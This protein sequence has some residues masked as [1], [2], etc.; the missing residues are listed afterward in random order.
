MIARL[1]EQYDLGKSAIQAR[2]HG[3]S[4]AEFGAKHG[5]SEHTIRK[6]RAFARDFSESDLEELCTSFRP[7]GLPLHWG[8]ISVLLAIQGK[9]GAKT[10]KKFQRWAIREGWTVPRLYREVRDRLG[11]SGHGRPVQ[12]PAEADEGLDTLTEAVELLLRR[13]ETL[14]AVAKASRDRITYSKCLRLCKI[15]TTARTVLR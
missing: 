13:A 1:R 4:I 12:L 8:Y 11:V 14:M 15:L 6:I 2:D 9:H 5:Y 3:A 10:R 7:N